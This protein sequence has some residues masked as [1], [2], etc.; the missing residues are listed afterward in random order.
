MCI[1]HS[2][3]VMREA[4][5]NDTSGELG[6][7]FPGWG[8]FFD[9]VDSG[10]RLNLTELRIKNSTPPPVPWRRYCRTKM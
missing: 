4:D 6:S 8:S 9:V 7:A 1:C 5:A 2:D 3:D 10:L